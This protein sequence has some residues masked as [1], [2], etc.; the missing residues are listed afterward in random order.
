MLCNGIL[1]GLVS[2][3][4]GTAAVWPWASLIIGFLGGFV[5]LAASKTVLYICKVDDPLDAFA[6]HGACGFWGVMAAAL[7]AAEITEQDGSQGPKGA[8]YGNGKP[9]GAGIIFCLADIGWT[10]G[11]SLMMFVPL[12]LAGLL[13]VSAEME[14]AGMDTS[15]HG[16]PA[17][18]D[19]P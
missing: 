19:K 16:G 7:F 14:D 2:I 6:V 17:Y 10:G 8:F 12:K 3:T 9:L 13:R 15:K 4:A 5:Y 18:N 11:C 1:A